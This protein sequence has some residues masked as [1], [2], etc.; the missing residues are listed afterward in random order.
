M[1]SRLRACS[2]A[3]AA[4]LF[5][6]ASGAETLSDPTRPPVVPVDP[7]RAVTDDRGTPLEI[8]AVFF[9]E[10]RRIAIVSGQRVATGDLVQ[11]ARVLR[12]ERDRVVL[13]RDGET[14]ELELVREDVKQPRPQPLDGDP[15]LEAHPAAPEP[16]AAEGIES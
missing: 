5:V 4:A 8:Q 11:S 1:S 7:N 12:I 10:G 2:I 6:T 3:F 13:F 9:A 16:A 14:L 15:S